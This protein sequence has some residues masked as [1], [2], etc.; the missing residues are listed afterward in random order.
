MIDHRPDPRPLGLRVDVAPREIGPEL[1]HELVAISRERAD[2]RTDGGW[3]VVAVAAA[4]ALLLSGG[5]YLASQQVERDLAPVPAGPVAP[6]DPEERAPDERRQDGAGSPD[7]SRDRVGVRDAGTRRAHSPDLRADPSAATGVSPATARTGAGAD[8]AVTR[9]RRRDDAAED[10]T[11]ERDT[12][13]TRDPGTDTDTDTPPVVPTP[14]DPAVQPPGDAAEPVDGSVTGPGPAGAPEC[15]RA[16]RD[17][18]C[19]AQGQGQGQ[20]PQQGTGDNGGGHGGHP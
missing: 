18:T 14:P 20:G 9:D 8:A 7:A 1:L 3:R 4:V 5:G 13:R 19:P 17:D 12:G 11:R 6:V 15:S 10:R 16:D 2:A